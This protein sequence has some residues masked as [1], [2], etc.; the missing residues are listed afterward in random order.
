M[1][2]NNNIQRI[3]FLIDLFN[4]GTLTDAQH[5]EL[6]NLLAMPQHQQQASLFLDQLWERTPDGQFFSKTKSEQLHQSIID[7]IAVP[8]A[9]TIKLNRKLISI[10]TAAAALIIVFSI[11][12]ITQYRSST[13][14]KVATKKEPA[15]LIADVGP[16][17]NKA[18][19]KLANNR[20]IVLDQ[21]KNGVLVKMGNLLVKKN[22]DGQLVFQSTA[23]NNP[24]A[25]LNENVLTTPAGG[26]YEVLLADGSH[27]WLNASSSLRFP[28]SFS[29]K[30]RKVA[31]IG[32]GYFEIS[33]SKDKP[34]IVNARDME[35]EV[36]GTHFN[37]TAYP[38]DQAMATTLV[39]GSVR[40]SQQ[41]NSV[42]LKPYEQANIK[43]D[44]FKVKKNVD[45]RDV[46]AWKNGYF[47]FDNEE[48][49]SVMRRLARWYNIEVEYEDP[50]VNEEFMGTIS[51][52]KNISEIL[53]LLQATGTIKFKILPPK[54]A[55]YERRV[56]VM[57]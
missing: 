4:K 20:L 9:K 43:N 41:A 36:L 19:L 50:N 23:V 28:S 30:E 55:R 17:G 14:T 15:A 26:Q 24:D 49:H 11:V 38:E 31:L 16:G 29:G 56:V 52:Y 57:K 5:Q 39:E 13:A 48:I 8:Q 44:S 3:T 18:T 46:L 10:I 7:Q 40:L 42:V 6:I 32:E 33:K 37:I 54:D 25:P 47:V 22:K 1:E 34:F 27:V 35:V 53:K 45:V 2:D 51:K 21:I 12:L